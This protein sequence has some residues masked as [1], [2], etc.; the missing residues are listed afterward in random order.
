MNV[1]TTLIL[2]VL[3]V[4]AVGYMVVFHSGW[5]V[6][7]KPAGTAAI[8]DK[9][10]LPK[11]GTVQKIV[12]EGKETPKVVLVRQEGKWRLTEP[13]EAPASEFPVD[14]IVSALTSARYERKYPAKDPDRPNDDLTYLSAPERTVS[15]TDD[16]NQT[17]VVKLG[18]NVPLAG[19]VYVQVGGDEAIYVASAS[20]REALNKTASDF[21]NTSVVDFQT[22]KATRL[23]VRGGQNYQLIKLPDGW[24][25]DK[26]YSAR[27]NSAN[28]DKLLSSLSG[29]RADKFIADKPGKEELAELG[30]ADPRLVVSVDVASEPPSTLPTATA[31]SPTTRPVKTTTIRFGKIVKDVVYAKLADQPSVFQVAKTKLDELQPKLETLR[32]PK[33][34][35]MAGK[36]VTAIEI[37]LAVDQSAKLQKADGVCKMVEPFP[38]TCDSEAVEKLLTTLREMKALNWVE[39]LGLEGLGLEPPAGTIA[40]QIRGSDKLLTVQVGK[41]TGESGQ[42]GYVREALSKSV[43]V[44]GSGDFATLNRSAPAYW[45]RV[46]VNLPAAATLCRIE[47]DRPDGKVG[48]T[49][50]EKGVY[51]LTQPLA[52]K[53]DAENA[54]NLANAL[55]SIQA[56]KI[57]AL[58]NALPP[59]FAQLKPIRVN[60]AYRMPAEAPASSPASSPTSMSATNPSTSSQPASAASTRSA[61]AASTQSGTA[62]S[63]RSPTA[64]ATRPAE[65]PYPSALLVAKE[66]DKAYVWFEGAKPIA[67]GE[68]DGAFYDKFAAELHER[69]VMKF[70]PEKAASLSMELNKNKMEFSKSGQGWQYRTDRFVQVDDAKMQQYLG[71]L[72]KIKAKQFVDY[73]DKPDLKRFGLD[74]PAM[75][76]SVQTDKPEPVKLTISRTGPVGS[77]GFYAASSASR[78]VFVLAPEES[79]KVQES[80]KGLKKE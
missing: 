51:W 5:F 23:E 37:K 59:R 48:L 24:A 53:A 43:A 75:V 70:E 2:L 20:V 63:T 7:E 1:K 39:P 40:L 18:R 15:L 42:T 8:E 66:K 36:D 28:V 77:D 19:E 76:I 49:A 61:T 65:I 67:V 32:E 21:R 38:A 16:K 27:A 57:I 17:Y 71:D 6:K 74:D 47:L 22:A 56:D 64:P 80:A 25:I 45:N 52:A 60:A 79:K 41:T 29:L 46:L 68:T 69:D 9:T 54:A 26:P 34:L 62:A 13:A 78:G 55:R 33:I 72:A 12:L 73:S 44:V 11:L 10:L 3:L 35:D 31:S 4:M 50:D 14:R 30:L 58:G